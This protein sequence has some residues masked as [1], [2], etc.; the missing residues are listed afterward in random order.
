MQ[1]MQAMKHVKSVGVGTY[2]AILLQQW[3]KG[4][5]MGDHK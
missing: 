3:T 1:L 2:N 5:S 4:G